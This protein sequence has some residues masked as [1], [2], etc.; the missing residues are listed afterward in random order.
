[1]AWINKNGYIQYINQKGK[2]FTPNADD[3]A[4]YKTEGNFIFNNEKIQNFQEETGVKIS[5]LSSDFTLEFKYYNNQIK[6]EIFALKKEQKIKVNFNKKQFQDY[7]IF[8]SKIYPINIT[9]KVINS[10]IKDITINEDGILDFHNYIKLTQELKNEGF[11]LTDN[12]KEEI[13][14]NTNFEHIPIKLKAKLY[15]YQKTGFNWLKFMVE[16]KCGAILADEMGLGKT[17][18]IITLL[19]YLKEINKN[20]NFLIIAPVSLLINW[21]R[22][23]KKFY[24]SLNC[25]IHHGTNRTGNW[26]DIIGYDVIITSYSLAVSDYSMFNQITWDL[27]ILDEAQ[28]IKN[29]LAE[30][31]TY[32]KKI[33][34]KLAIAVTGTPFENHLTDVW[35]LMDYIEP[36]FFG[37][38]TDF[39]NHFADSIESATTIESMITPFLLRRMVK[40]VGNNLPPLVDIPEAIEMSIEEAELYEK[41]RIN[42]EHTVQ[43]KP[44]SLGDIQNLRMFCTH[45]A[46]YDEQYSSID[47]YNISTKYQ[48]LC[49]I[50]NEIIAKNEKIIIFTSFN[51][52]SE[53]MQTDLHQRFNVP[54]YYINGSV[55]SKKR[56]DIIDEYS[57]ISGSS[58][59]ILNPKAAGVGL[60]ITAANHVIHYNLEW[61]P[62]SEL[63]ATARA[64]RTGQTKT[65]FVHRLFYVN[66]IDEIINEKIEFKK[67][68]AD[69]LIV[70][71]D[72]TKTDKN[73]LLRALKMSPIRRNY[74]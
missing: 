64:Y 35:S 52:M 10:L 33:K 72:G 4:N 44:S 8:D 74:E 20:V 13:I 60:N 62:A 15:P 23:I 29:P 22:E 14:N 59:L 63:Q 68:I 7:I 55:E 26:K 45:P 38:L 43:L 58:I 25:Y 73:E 65:V 47:P 36:G 17:L 1:M 19:G 61:N 56:Q 3:F 21:E 37:K 40:E 67:N 2:T 70:G 27:L 41:H 49:D 51:K 9:I 42:F 34:H 50:I 39:E 12:V 30:R 69:N 28:N 24:P 31:T 48:R 57:Q 66:T 6:F 53:I 16:S 54:I 46:V 5:T 11:R 32:I 71:I 18:Q